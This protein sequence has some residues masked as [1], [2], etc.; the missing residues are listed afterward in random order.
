MDFILENP[1]ITSSFE[2]L[3]ILKLP[4]T[5]KS[6]LND[7][8]LVK[9]LFNSMRKSP[10]IKDNFSGP[11]IDNKSKLFLNLNEPTI[12][13]KLSNPS[14]LVNR[15]L[16][17]IIKSPP[18]EFNFLKISELILVVPIINKLPPIDSKLLK[19]V[20]LLFAPI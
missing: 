11:F 6:P 16:S 17:S 18:I 20:T 13:R 8:I 7:T 2:L 12:E 5:S 14:K 3:L 9:L 15:L 1:F 4:L 19:A 10:P